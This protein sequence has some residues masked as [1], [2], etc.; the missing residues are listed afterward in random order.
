MNVGGY[1]AELTV[2]KEKVWVPHPW[3][4]K[5]SFHDLMLFTLT[6]LSASTAENLSETWPS[7]LYVSTD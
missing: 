1:L 2:F 3:E 4:V 5:F 6:C 7:Y